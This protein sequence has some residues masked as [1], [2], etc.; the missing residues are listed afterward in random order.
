MAGIAGFILY[1]LILLVALFTLLFI[2][3]KLISPFLTRTAYRLAS[4]IYIK[5]TPVKNILVTM[6]L[7]F[8]LMAIA[9]VVALFLLSLEPSNLAL[10]VFTAAFFFPFYWMGLIFNYLVMMTNHY[11]Y[12]SKMGS[13]LAG[14]QKNDKVDYI[15]DRIKLLLKNSALSAMGHLIVVYVCI[16]GMVAFGDMPESFSF[17]LLLSMPVSML[18]WVYFTNPSKEEQRLRRITVYFMIAVFTMCNYYME[19]IGGSHDDAVNYLF[20]FIPAVYL[21]LDSF[22]QS[23]IK[24]FTSYK[25]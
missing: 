4:F 3:K 1:V 14:I 16:V 15:L 18:T 6:E 11:P 25:S 17:L 13:A 12:T 24:D 7:V 10:M 9:E 20:L 5:V 21:A 8:F 2:L 22:T 23:I 19:F